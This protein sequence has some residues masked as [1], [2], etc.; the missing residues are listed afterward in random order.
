VTLS[1]HSSEETSHY[2]LSLRN[3]GSSAFPLSNR[4]VTRSVQSVRSPLTR[5]NS[6][7]HAWWDIKEPA[8]FLGPGDRRGSPAPQQ[9]GAR[10][11]RDDQAQHGAANRRSRARIYRRYAHTVGALRC[12]I[13]LENLE[14]GQR[15]E[16]ALTQI[17]VG[18]IILG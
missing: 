10:V 8:R 13:Y 14:T 1:D 5:E 2:G 9:K 16:S 11:F 4:R 15:T 6:G 3:K 7:A 18:N 17:E 12:A